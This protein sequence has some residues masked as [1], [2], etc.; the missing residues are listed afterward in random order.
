MDVKLS[1]DAGFLSSEANQTPVRECAR[2][3]LVSGASL[4][5]SWVSPPFWGTW[6]RRV[7]R[8]G[9]GLSRGAECG[10][11]RKRPAESGRAPC[12]IRPGSWARNQD[13]EAHSARACQRKWSSTKVAMKK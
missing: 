3:A 4:M 6:R 11:G 2:T 10:K 1:S 5:H 7:D 8:L 9:A 13:D 12:P